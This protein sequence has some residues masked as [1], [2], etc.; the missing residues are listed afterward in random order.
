MGLSPGEQIGPYRI[1][2]RIG[3]GGMG[4]VFR[5]H[6]TR[7]DRDVAVK[8]L[9]AS[10]DRTMQRRLEQEARSASALNHP[11]IITV[12]DVGEY[13]RAPYVVMELVD[14]EPLRETIRG[15]PVALK[16]LL[17]YG[18]QI[19]DGLAAAHQAGITHRDLK[20]ENIMATKAGRIK[21]LDFGLARGGT[22]V[23]GSAEG[24]T[25]TWQPTAPGTVMGTVAYMSPEQA[26]GEELG[27][28]SDQF[29]FGHILYE[30]ARGKRAF[31][32]K[33]APETMAAII[34]EEAEPLGTRVPPPLEWLIQRA[35][36]KEPQERYA[37]TIDLFRDLRT[38]RDK[39]PGPLPSLKKPRSN[40]AWYAIVAALAAVAVAAILAWPRTAPEVFRYVP[41]AVDASSETQPAWSPDGKTMAYVREVDGIGQ[42]FTKP[43]GAGNA[44]QISRCVRGCVHPFWSPDGAR[45]YYIDAAA[46]YSVSSAGGESSQVLADAAQAALSRD[47]KTLAFGKRTAGGGVFLY[48]F[49]DSSVKPYPAPL[50]GQSMNRALRFSPDGK[51]IGALWPTQ[52]EHNIYSVLWILPFPPG[53][54]P[55]SID[56]DA[57]SFAWMPDSRHLV[58]ALGPIGPYEH[59]LSMV[60]TE[61][62]KSEPITSGTG[63]E[64]W[65]A[66]SPDGTRI[67]FASGVK[68]SD[69][70]EIPLDGSGLKTIL[71]SSR[72]EENPS[73]SPDGSQ[74]LFVQDPTGGGNEIWLRSVQ[75]GWARPLLEARNGP[76]GSVTYTNPRFAP[77]GRRLAY[78]TWE[79]DGHLIWVTPLGGGS[80][81]RVA[82][83]R[84]HQHH[85]AWSPDGKW[86]AYRAN[87]G[88]KRN[89][90]KVSSG[91]GKPVL[92]W[93]SRTV[94]GCSW[95]PKGDLLAFSDDD[96][97]YFVTPGG[98]GHRLASKM[99]PVSF[100][101]SGDGAKLLMIALENAQWGLWS[102]DVKS[103][104]RK[105]ERTLPFPASATIRGF[106]LHP[107][108]KRIA[109]SVRIPR[110]DI[111]LLDGFRQRR[112]FWR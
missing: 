60:D 88:A 49:A 18:V 68:D 86:I 109:T 14:G 63:S 34:R 17:D 7:L 8:V 100:G 91:G 62:G 78:E 95:S 24:T 40:G 77:D 82:P 23:A 70:I 33:T 104:A 51:K 58:A 94:N 93:E 15:G 85:P 28:A 64:D 107:D 79:P 48:N 30:M 16:K 32:R 6:D 19:A 73:W 11:N 90:E 110:D 29:S 81:I 38:L 74:Y 52:K 2:S 31:D 61:T 4:E 35:M 83:E 105:L 44:T 20:P 21:I 80:P 101:F 89:L 9:A 71:A 36:A 41:F 37:S 13:N 57:A 87:V 67:A 55:R 47:G 111:W 27:C 10:E 54:T 69:L 92:I 97:V 84:N 96:G 26:Q 66:V 43:L 65:P 59:H 25:Y 3:A 76:K 42:V 108:G 75:G 102:V 22:G 72:S 1:I 12:H 46:L 53:E 45:V 103:A 56:L 39:L 112:G 50:E 99:T 5:A 106:S 98:A